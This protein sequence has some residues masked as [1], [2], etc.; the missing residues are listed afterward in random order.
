MTAHA[1]GPTLKQIEGKRSVRKERT[2]MIG[3]ARSLN[4]EATKQVLKLATVALASV[5]YFALAVISLHFLRPD[6][7]P[8]SQPTSDYAVG[9][10]GFVMSTAFAAMSLAAWS[11][12]I[13]L[14]QTVR[15]TTR[16]RVGMGLLGVWATGVLIAMLFPTDVGDAPQT[17][18]GTIHRINGFAAFF[19]LALGA[20]LVSRRFKHDDRWRPVDRPAVVLSALMLAEFAAVGA[21][22]A[23]DSGLGGLG[24]RIMLITVL[25]WFYLVAGRLRSL[26]R[27]GA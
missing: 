16:L 14:G 6:Y 10:S 27:Q 22:I 18:S 23:S 26:G 9:P 5:T 19:S 12:V 21:A 25:T 11:V 13:G 1:P 15:Q 2:T 24:Q 8:I 4:P 7:S 20:F 3:A 17:L